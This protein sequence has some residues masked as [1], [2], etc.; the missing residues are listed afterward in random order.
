MPTIDTPTT[1]Y[2]TRREVPAFLAKLGYPITH[3]YLGKLASVGGGPIYRM[4]G[5]RALY[6]PEDVLAWIET[7]TSAPV[8]CAAQ[9]GGAQA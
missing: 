5:N 1:A 7:R 8:T 2:M 4:F 3:K 9:R 6:T